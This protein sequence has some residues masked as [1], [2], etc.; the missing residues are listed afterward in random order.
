MVPVPSVVKFKARC[1]GLCLGLEASCLGLGLS[2]PI[3]CLASIL[4]VS[5]AGVLH[6]KLQCAYLRHSGATSHAQRDSATEHTHHIYA[7]QYQRP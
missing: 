3:C 5:A 1:L 6:C 2:I 7:R 4:R